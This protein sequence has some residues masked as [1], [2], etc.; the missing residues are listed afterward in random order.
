MVLVSDLSE[1][2]LGHALK[3]KLSGTTSNRYGVGTRVVVSAAG[4]TY[5]R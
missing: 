5:T 2:R 4:A 3:I 1:R